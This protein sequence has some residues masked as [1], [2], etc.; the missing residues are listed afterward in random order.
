M[1]NEIGTVVFSLDL[2][3]L[4]RPAAMPKSDVAAFLNDT[5]SPQ[6][7]RAGEDIRLYLQR[8]WDDMQPLRAE[9]LKNPNYF[10]DQWEKVLLP[11]FRNLLAPG[12]IDLAKYKAA[13]GDALTITVQARAPARCPVVLIIIP[14]I[15]FHETPGDQLRLHREGCEEAAAVERGAAFRNRISASVVSRGFSSITQ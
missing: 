12:T 6:R 14:R 2:R 1:L 5:D 8:I 10:T 4:K 9:L 15:L 11:H 7:A 3:S 13:D